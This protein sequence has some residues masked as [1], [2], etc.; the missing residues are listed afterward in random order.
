MN[1]KLICLLAFVFSLSLGFT[2]CSD[3]DDD[4][5]IVDLKLDKTTVSVEKGKTVEVKI[6]QGNGGY[7]AD[8]ADKAIATAAEKDGVITITGVA[9]GSTTV[10]VKDKEGKTATITVTVTDETP[11]P[12]DHTAEVVGVYSGNLEIPAIGIEDFPK[13]IELTREDVNKLKLALNDFSFPIN[14]EGGEI[15]MGDIIV[16]NVPLSEKEGV[17]TLEETT[18]TI[19][20][21]S[22]LTNEDAEVDVKV[23]GTVTDG[24]LELTIDVTKVPVL[25]DLT[26]TFVGEI[27]AEEEGE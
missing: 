12:T 24:K 18:A 22:P 6:T 21:K 14:E 5:V 17:Y 25:E 15:S 9:K 27:P 10:P 7:T 1:K 11:A 26:V 23:N 8:P 20:I 13:D 19:T 3:D 2:A 16:N 4:P